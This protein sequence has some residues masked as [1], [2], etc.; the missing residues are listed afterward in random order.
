VPFHDW[1]NSPH[2]GPASLG[3]IRP[4]GTNR[5]GRPAIFRKLPFGGTEVRRSSPST[6]IEI[7]TMQRRFLFLAAAIVLAAATTGVQAHTFKA[8]DIA[9]GHPY[10]RATAPGQP[11]GGAYLRLENHGAQGDKLV[12]ASAD[13]SRSVELHEMQMQGDVMRMRQIAAVDIPAHQSVVLEPG[14]V[15]IM[16]VGLKAPLKQGE[17][18]QMTL[19]FEKA[20]EVKVD[21]VVEAVNAGPMKHD[22]KH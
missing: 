3:A 2:A 18:F 5:G 22:M 21:V 16:L 15:H 6:S 17:R 14:G 4:V 10:A 9:I 12:S 11:T 19:K 1:Q 20:G 7:P 8:G 13:V